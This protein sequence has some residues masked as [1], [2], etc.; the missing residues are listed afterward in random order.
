MLSARSSLSS[1]RLPPDLPCDSISTNRSGDA[2]TRRIAFVNEKGGSCKTTLAVHVGAYLAAQRG[3]RVLLVD[4]DP[5]GHLGKTLGYDVGA[6]K[7]TALELLLDDGRN[8]ALFIRRTRFDHLDVVLSNKSIAAFPTI[9]AADPSRDFKLARAMDRL[10]GYDLI[11]FDSP[12]SFS[13]IMVNL[14]MAAREIVVPVNA[15]YL[16]LDGC[17]ELVRTIK[18]LAASHGITP[19]VIS[20]IVPTLYRPTRMAD[21][22][23]ERL[24]AHFPKEVYPE[25]LRYDVK[26]EEAQSHGRTIWEYAPHARAAQMLARLGERIL[27]LGIPAVRSDRSESLSRVGQHPSL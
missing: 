18:V 7:R 11:L 15:S 16:A 1:R 10:D 9:A 24:Q 21:A 6:Y 2:L 14:L 20:L 26:V 25:A 12:A 4:L 23:I 27:L 13:P 3:M 19:A 17:A 22:V 5:Q 8:P